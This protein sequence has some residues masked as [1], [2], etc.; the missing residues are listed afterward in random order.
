MLLLGI[1]ISTF[2]YSG[3]TGQ[4][5]EHEVDECESNPCENNATCIDGFNNFTCA[6]Q[7]GFTGRLCQIDIDFCVLYPCLNNG[8]CVGERNEQQCWHIFPTQIMMFIDWHHSDM[9][10]MIYTPND[11]HDITQLLSFIHIARWLI[12][13]TDYRIEVVNAYSEQWAMTVKR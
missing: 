10:N 4:F 5:C 11:L 12:L 7:E 8:L 2:F 1:K 3:Y 6:C 9:F 13:Q